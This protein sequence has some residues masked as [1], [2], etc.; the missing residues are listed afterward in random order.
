M[1]YQQAFGRFFDDTSWRY[2]RDDGGQKY[3]CF[4]GYVSEDKGSVK[5]ELY[6]AVRD[7]GTFQLY[8]G[9][10]NNVEKDLSE[11]YRYETEPF[12]AFA[13]GGK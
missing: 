3:V 6:Y 9:A 8:K 10:L 11:M 2:G 7:D 5:I 12:S 4:T 13:E 1:S